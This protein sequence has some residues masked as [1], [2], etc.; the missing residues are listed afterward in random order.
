MSV[1][2]AFAHDPLVEWTKPVGHPLQ[3]PQ[4]FMR[5]RQGRGKSEKEIRSSAERNLRPIRQK[6]RGVMEDVE[7]VSVPN[8][9]EFLIQQA[10]SP[11]NLVSD[12]DLAELMDVGPHVP[13]LGCVVVKSLCYM[14]LMSKT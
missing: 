3:F 14:H 1:L 8:H 12:R 9:V 5:Y 2:E 10:T 6:L 11:Q 13:R 4:R 7:V